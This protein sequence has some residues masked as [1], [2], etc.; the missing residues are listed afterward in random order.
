VDTNRGLSY[1]R[2]GRAP[3]SSTIFS[4]F[5]QILLIE[6]PWGLLHCRLT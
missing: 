3:H 2:S 1:E 5:D 4:Q 6:A